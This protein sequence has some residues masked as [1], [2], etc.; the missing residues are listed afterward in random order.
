MDKQKTILISGRFNILHS[1]HLRLFAYAKGL[2]GKLIVAVFADKLIKK[3]SF[4]NQEDRLEALNLCSIVD[5]VVLVDQSLDSTLNKYKP[6]IVLKGKDHEHKYNEELPVI[7]GYGGRLIFSSGERLYSSIDLINQE[8][9]DE[10]ETLNHEVDDFI[11]RHNIEISDLATY[12]ENFKN[13]KVCVIGDVIIDEYIIC[14][15]LGLSSEE[16]A[17]VVSPQDKKRFLGGAGIVA[18]HA[19]SLGADVDFITIVGKDEGR[20]FIQKKLSTYDINYNLIEDTNRPTS[21]KQRFRADDRTL[22]KVSYLHQNSI[23]NELENKIFNFLKGKI[24][25]FDLLIFSDFNYGCLPQSLV[26]RII[27][28]SK[29][30][31][32]VMTA[33]SQSSSQNGNVARFK[34]MDLLTPTEKEARLSIK[35]FEDGLVVISEQLMVESN[36]KNI[37]LKL[38]AEGV[39]IHLGEDKELAI[40]TDKIPALNHVAKDTAG[41]GDSMLVGSSLALASKASIWESSLI[42]SLMAYI[43]VSRL[44]NTPISSS[45]LLTKIKNLK[46]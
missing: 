12:I 34:G 25:D 38:G 46:K 27:S 39:F 13:I 4:V 40:F 10:K 44:G 28:I 1:G 45:D 5:E 21:T 3:K 18:A 30:S 37:L 15:T 22:L 42:G 11:E 17:I 7:E 24:N 20:D 26:D 8:I 35:N 33:D 29:R 14:N 32:I 9:N 23:S 19:A 43:Q 31:K 6:S 2:A 36:A 16:P 41:A